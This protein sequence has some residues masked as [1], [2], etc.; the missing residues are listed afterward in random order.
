MTDA[1]LLRLDAQVIGIT[2]SG[3]YGHVVGK[4]LAFAYVGPQ[5][6]EPGTEFEFLIIGERRRA[7]VL[8]EPA[9]DPDN[10]RLRS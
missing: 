10:V 3:A 5:Y 6:A 7:T 1:K 4:T 2:T 9:Y 8:P